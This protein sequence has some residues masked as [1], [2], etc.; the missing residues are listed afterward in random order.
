VD[1][2][3]CAARGL[4]DDWTLTDPTRPFASVVPFGF[5]TFVHRHVPAESPANRMLR[6][7]SRYF[8]RRRDQG[9][10]AKEQRSLVHHKGTGIGPSPVAR[11]VPLP[12][13]NASEPDHTL[14]Y[15][16]SKASNQRLFS[17]CNP[18]KL[19]QTAPKCQIRPLIG[20]FWPKF[21][22]IIAFFDLIC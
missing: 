20:I 10:E 2:F 17:S 21:A 7:L 13:G 3:P 11:A 12:V 19:A 1:A 5:F 22:I 18:P 4:V 16:S 6:R 14:S 15:F 9:V 8:R